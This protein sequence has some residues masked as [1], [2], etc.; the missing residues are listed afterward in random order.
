MAFEYSFS[1]NIFWHRCLGHRCRFKSEYLSSFSLKALALYFRHFLTG[2][3]LSCSVIYF[4][5]C[6]NHCY[7]R[8]QFIYF[9]FFFFGNFFIR[10]TLSLKQRLL[11]SHFFFIFFSFFFA[12]YDFILIVSFPDRRVIDLWIQWIFINKLFRQIWIFF[13]VNLY[14][15]WYAQMKMN[16]AKAM[17]LDRQ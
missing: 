1:L 8:I 11:L 3:I 17:T 4:W 7:Q 5:L 9:Y 13:L 10:K 6:F 12:R 16:T 15:H 2:N 14:A